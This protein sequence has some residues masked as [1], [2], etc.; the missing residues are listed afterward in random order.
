MEL[1]PDYSKTYILPPTIED[2]IP[3]NYPARFMREF[4]DAINLED[5]GF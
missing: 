5:C 4:V 3:E 2:R 1:T